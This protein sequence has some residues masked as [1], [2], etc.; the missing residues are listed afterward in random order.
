MVRKKI[1]IRV[2]EER[3]LRNA[4]A[5]NLHLNLMEYFTV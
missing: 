1:P 5:I 3:D 4:I 2:S